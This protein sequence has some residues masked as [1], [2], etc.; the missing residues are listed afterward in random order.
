PVVL[1]RAR[2]RHPKRYLQGPRLAEE[3][4]LAPDDLVFE[5]FLNVLR[6]AEG[7]HPEE[8]EARTALGWATVAPTVE[9]AVADGLLEQGRFGFRPSQLGWRFHND[10]QA[11][12]LPETA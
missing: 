1:R 3:R 2:T 12:F 9:Q 4:R 8:F 5:F 7:F 11:R 6:L 10:L